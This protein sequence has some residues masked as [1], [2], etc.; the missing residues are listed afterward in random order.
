MTVPVPIDI[1]SWRSFFT[2]AAVPMWAVRGGSVLLANPLAVHLFGA[3]TEAELIARPAAVLGASSCEAGRPIPLRIERLG[4]EPV[5]ALVLAWDCEA[6]I[7]CFQACVLDLSSIDHDW[8]EH[9]LSTQSTPLTGTEEL[10]RGL[11]SSKV[12]CVS[13]LG[14]DGRLL[15]MNPGGR[16]LM[17]APDI[18]ALQGKD[19][20]RWWTGEHRLEAERSLNEARHSGVGR[21]IGRCAKLDGEMRWWDVVITPMLDG[22][23]SVRRLLCVSRDVTEMKQA[24]LVESFERQVLEAAA[25]A[26]PLRETLD[27]ICQLAEFVADGAVRCAILAADDANEDRLC[28]FSAPSIPGLPDTR[29]S[30]IELEAGRG[31]KVKEATSYFHSLL[32]GPEGTVLGM[33]VFWV[34][35]TAPGGNPDL[36]TR[37]DNGVNLAALA[38]TRDAHVRRI[39][40]KQDRLTAISKAAPVGLYQCDASGA[41]IYTNER[42]GQMTG[43]S[44]EKRGGEG[45]VQSIHPEDRGSVVEVWREARASGTEFRAEYRLAS[46]TPEAPQWVVSHEMPVGTEG[47]IGTVTDITELKSALAAVAEGAERFQALVNNISQFCWM[48][49]ANG[50]VFWYS[51]RWYEYSGTTLEDMRGWGWRSLHH[52]DHVD[53]VVEK[54]SRCW[55]TGETWEDTFPLRGKDGKYRWFL[56]RAL[57]IRDAAGKVLRWFGTNTDITEQRQMEAALHRQNLALQRSNEDLSQFAFIA[58]HDLQE[59]VRM[60]V[61]YAQLVRR[62][63]AL[64]EKSAGYIDSIVEAAGGMSKLI[65][66][67]LS[68]AEA[69]VESAEQPVDLDLNEIVSSV[70]QTLRA[71]IEECGAQMRVETLPRVKGLSVQVS[72]VIQNLVS[73]SLKYRRRGVGLVVRIG[74]ERDGAAADWKISVRDNGE[75]FAPEHAER[76]FDFMKRLHGRDIP[77]SG[78]GLAICKTIV[79]RNGGAIGADGRPGEGATFWFTIPAAGAAQ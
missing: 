63:A 75:G 52:P 39:R 38:L 22:N 21:F 40:H 23:G 56:S 13:I 71:S 72:Q 55:Q 30:R 57:P 2:A 12:D 67:L 8:I 32:R 79:E 43:L 19:W 76:I 42:H 44:M 33:F 34:T 3:E 18:R 41:W 16:E 11:L 70:L 61:T 49:D 54:I 31:P 59:P 69:S 66:H 10:R 73:N 46:S 77:G 36:R 28:V 5:N 7:R 17:A 68:Y 9:C 26:R 1:E 78:I 20:L 65:R 4:H 62:S 24:Q 35:S 27:A 14:V 50:W 37:L 51:D 64:D 74:A 25:S 6:G 45:W 60:I 53:R 58:S 47:Y 29:I 15:Y 48:A